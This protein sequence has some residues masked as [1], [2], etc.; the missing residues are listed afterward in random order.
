MGCGTST[1][2]D[3][4]IAMKTTNLPGLDEFFNDVQGFIDEIYEAQDPIDEA[5]EQLL[6]NTE[7]QEVDGATAHQAAVGTVFCLASQANG[8]AVEDLV[9]ITEESPFIEIDT[10]KASG[11][12]A[13]AANN[14]KAYIMAIVAAKD[15]IEP[16]VKKAQEFA[17]KSTELP[18]KVQGEIKAAGGLGA[19]QKIKAVRYTTTNV[20][21]VAKLP[22]LVNGFKD[23][24]TEALKSIMGATKELNAKKSRLQD[25]GS[26]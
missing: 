25:I 20:R 15:R 4:K 5:L 26:K 16:L 23:S 13:D 8:V 22:S 2:E 10:S 21:N 14:L 1:G 7:F 18:G 19:M 6:E 12:P 9:T 17:E 11:P 24:V 3:G